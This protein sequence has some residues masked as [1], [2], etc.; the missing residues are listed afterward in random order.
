MNETVLRLFDKVSKG[1]VN[2]IDPYLTEWVLGDLILIF[3]DEENGE[4]TVRV[5]LKKW[6]KELTHLHI[7]NEDIEKF[8]KEI[9][10]EQKAIVV[11][12]HLL[13]TDFKIIDKTEVKKPNFFRH[14]SI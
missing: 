1:K 6:S 7:V 4:H 2:F 11:E 9:D 14:Y 12:N 3:S 13:W 5:C 10:D 8:V